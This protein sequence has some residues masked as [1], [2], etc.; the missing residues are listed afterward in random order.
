MGQLP[1]LAAIDVA[2]RAF[3]FRSGHFPK[4]VGEV[5]RAAAILHHDTWFLGFNHVRCVP[6]DI[7]MSWKGG[8]EPSN[9]AP[10]FL[11]RGDCE[12]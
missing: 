11:P 8:S 1:L 5:A 12:Q 7:T 9:T 10:P 6:L 4:E 2:Q 3:L